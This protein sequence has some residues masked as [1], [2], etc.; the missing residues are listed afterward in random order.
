MSE[1][2]HITP[3]GKEGMYILDTGSWRT[4]RPVMN[5]EHCINCGICLVYCPVNA[6][7]RLDGRIIL[8]M[9][10]CKGCGICAHECPRQAIT[11]MREEG[12]SN[13]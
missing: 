2:M 3:I 13:G 4:F 5:D 12:N 8:T 9:D 1:R 6:I 7:K 11:M 10:F